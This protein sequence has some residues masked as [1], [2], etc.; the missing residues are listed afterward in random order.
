MFKTNCLKFTSSTFKLYIVLIKFTKLH[1]KFSFWK[2]LSLHKICL[3]NNLPGFSRAVSYSIGDTS[4]KDEDGHHL[5][6]WIHCVLDAVSS[7]V[8]I[9]FIRTSTEVLF[10]LILQV[11]RMGRP[12]APSPTRRR[13]HYRWTAKSAGTVVWSSGSSWRCTAR[14]GV[15]SCAT[16]PPTCRSSTWTGCGRARASTSEWGPWTRE[17]TANRP[18]WPLTPSRRPSGR[19][20]PPPELRVRIMPQGELQSKDR[21]AGEE[22]WRV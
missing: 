3:R 9:P 15:R 1:F 21:L 22:R 16:S 8:Y 4:D 12:T 5:A 11:H 17:A 20:A 2:G 19:W 13:T 18:G 7:E 14:R 10:Q 6:L